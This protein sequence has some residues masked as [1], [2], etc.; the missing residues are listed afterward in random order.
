MKHTIKQRFRRGASI[1]IALLIFLLCALAGVSALMMAASNAGR[2]SHKSEQDYYS[3]SSAAL[4]FV[5]LF[6]SSTL[7]Y[8]SKQIAF[9]YK[10]EW[11]FDAATE[12]SDPANQH[13]S[14]DSYN[15]T[16]PTESGSMSGGSYTFRT[17]SGKTDGFKLQSIICGQCDKIV[18]YLNIPDEWYARV[19]DN[20]GDPPKRP[21]APEP[22]T[23]KFTFTMKDYPQFGTVTCTMRMEANYDLLFTFLSES[24]GYS[25][26][27]Y[28][29]AEVDPAI[30]AK[31]PEYVY[32]DVDET[33]NFKKGYL[34]QIS[35][36]IVTV[37]W[38]K[39]NI[40]ISR[41]ETVDTFTEGEKN[42]E[43]A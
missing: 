14:T 4:Y 19:K 39:S 8:T 36:L 11:T 31:D 18:P 30:V 27:L 25:I 13:N 23:D 40:T 26:T 17:E 7:T 10:R 5:D 28:W 6:A 42:E 15:L 16:I 3:V 9:E 21:A 33:N 24:G 22:V 20:E 2:Y 32:A 35:T 34:R 41:G 38:R 29:V 37:K 1:A 12:G 43:T